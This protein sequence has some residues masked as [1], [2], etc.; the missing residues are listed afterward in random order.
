MHASYPGFC[1]YEHGHD[2]ELLPKLM[3]SA[4]LLQDI[5]VQDV[6]VLLHDYQ[7]LTPAALAHANAEAGLQGLPLH[8][9]ASRVPLPGRFGHFQAR[10]LRLG[11]VAAL[12]ADYRSMLALQY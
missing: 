2:T 10:D 9:H 3:H 8:Q 5:R 12:Q 6:H 4:C 11:D 7:R 1:S